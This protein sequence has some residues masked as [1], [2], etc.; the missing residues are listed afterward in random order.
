MAGEDLSETSLQDIS[1]YFIFDEV[2]N[3]MTEKGCEWMSKMDSEAV[4]QI[5]L[6]SKYVDVQNRIG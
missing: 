2:G 1:R 4:G 3:I 6:E 5:R